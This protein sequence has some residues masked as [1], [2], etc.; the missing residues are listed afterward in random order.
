MKAF[1]LFSGWLSNSFNPNYFSI[2][3]VEWHTKLK[4]HMLYL[5]D[6]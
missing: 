1:T 3:E 4:G 6:T 2:I 5:I